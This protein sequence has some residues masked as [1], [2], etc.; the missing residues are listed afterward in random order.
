MAQICRTLTHA[1]SLAAVFAT[2][3]RPAFGN[4]FEDW[5]RE[6]LLFAF[7]HAIEDGHRNDSG[8]AC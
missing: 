2:P 6:N 8:K 4:G 1:Y 5:I 3:L 7:F